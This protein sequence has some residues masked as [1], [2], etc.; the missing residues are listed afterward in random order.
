MGRKRLYTPEEAYTR[1]MERSKQYLRNNQNVRL[2]NSAKQRAEKQ[3]IGFDL[4]IEDIV[5]PTHCPYLGVEITN[6]MGQGRIP[7]NASIDR[8]DSTK[9]Y[10]KDNIQ[11]ISDL[12]NRMK[13]DATKIELIT[14]A[15]N[16]LRMYN[17]E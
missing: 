1:I 14:F 2:Y 3:K 6:I 7:T 15:E 4:T 11:I 5:I 13:Q 12:A 10:T 17:K 8:I 9:P 16:I